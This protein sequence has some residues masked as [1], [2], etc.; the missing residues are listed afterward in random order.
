MCCIL[1]VH[2]RHCAPRIWSKGPEDASGLLKLFLFIL[3]VSTWL[4]APVVLLVAAARAPINCF[5]VCLRRAGLLPSQIRIPAPLDTPSLANGASISDIRRRSVAP[6]W[7]IG[8]RRMAGPLLR[9]PV[10]RTKLARFSFVC[11]LCFSV[12]ICLAH[13]RAAPRK[14]WLH[15]AMVPVVFLGAHRPRAHT[16]RVGSISRRMA[17]VRPPNG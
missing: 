13:R 8:D 15:I 12:D 7:L 4:R 1:P 10:L 2:S 17:S 3:S 5:T 6:A 11:L 14:I 9:L 16:R